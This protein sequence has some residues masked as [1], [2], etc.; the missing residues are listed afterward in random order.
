MEV[1]GYT[2]TYEIGPISNVS[3]E[4]REKFL[5]EDNDGCQE[6]LFDELDKIVFLYNGIIV[7]DSDESEFIPIDKIKSI[8]YKRGS[9]KP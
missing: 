9:Y 2:I 3:I 5:E 1:G 8:T 7:E 6:D 4:Y